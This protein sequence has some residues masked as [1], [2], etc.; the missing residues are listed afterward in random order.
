V[1]LDTVL[2]AARARPL[3]LRD[4][5]VDGR[6][7]AVGGAR[8][9]LRCLEDALGFFQDRHLQVVELV[10]VAIAR[11]DQGVEHTLRVDRHLEPLV[12][13]DGLRGGGIET[14]PAKRGHHLAHRTGVALGVQAEDDAPQRAKRCMPRLH[15]RA[16][17]AHH[18]T[19]H[20]RES[21]GR[22]GFAADA[23]LQ[24][25]HR[26]FGSN[27]TGEGRHRRFHVV[28][29]DRQ[30]HVR[31]A[32]NIGGGECHGRTRVCYVF[33]RGRFET[34]AAVTDRVDER[35]TSD[36]ENIVAVEGQH[37]AQDAPHRT[38]TIDDELH[39]P[40]IQ[41][42]WAHDFATVELIAFQAS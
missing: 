19:I 30:Q 23:V 26:S 17:H 29:L 40:L 13:A 11:V 33:A 5:L 9:D 18:G 14:R 10:F 15:H 16:R 8:L 28:G 27:R 20:A 7:L 24:A 21:L 37:A 36:Q 4:H 42:L 38:R 25:H 32:G 41:R 39:T 12:L 35:R 2:V 3:D 34:Q 22:D 31:V 6:I 1:H